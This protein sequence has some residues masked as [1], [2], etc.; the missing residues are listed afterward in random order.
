MMMKWMC[1][2]C[3]VMGAVQTGVVEAAQFRFLSAAVYSP[4]IVAGEVL[5]V[6]GGTYYQNEFGNNYAPSAVA[7]GVVP[8]LE[9][10]SYMAVD[11]IGRSTADRSAMA[12]TGSWPDSST[13]GH[14]LDEMTLSGIWWE[15]G[16]TMSGSS[17]SGLDGVMIAQLTVTD[18]AQLVG[19]AVAF[20]IGGEDPLTR[21]AELDGAPGEA[22]PGAN[23]YQVRSYLTAQPVI[24]GH[25]YDTYEIWIEQVPTPC[26]ALIAPGAL[27]VIGRRRS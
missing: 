25:A 7:I 2:V 1:R 14:F 18:G 16:G 3:V 27:L 15:A 23:V 21:V 22:F 4:D 9:Y 19:P 24:E 6:S 10:D 13:S 12:P 5:T 11:P 26:T 20:G 8:D 17:P